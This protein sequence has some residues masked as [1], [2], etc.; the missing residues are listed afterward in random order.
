M[1]EET[2][3]KINGLGKAGDIIAK[4]CRVLLIIGFVG[5]IIGLIAIIAVP[6]DLVKVDVGTN[7]GVKVDFSR[8]GELSEA[9]QENARQ[10]LEKSLSEQDEDGR[11]AD[12]EV[13]A[14]S[15]TVHLVTNEITFGLRNLI[16]PM[17][18]ALLYVAASYVSMRFIGLLCRAFRDCASPFEEKVIR[19]MKNFA[20][21]LIPWVALSMISD[22]IISRS[23]FSVNKFSVGVN[24]GTVLLVLL[25]LGLCRIF[26]YGAE[27]Q[28][29][30]DETL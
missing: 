23:M 27:L 17:V 24:L 29:E 18:V 20:F 14:S 1:K 19:C 2:V 16:G 10:G 13:T 26:R 30:H 4:V 6:K 8:Y 21:S 22:S 3:R 15:V 7:I 5:I 9:D 28:K 11:I 12:Y 25:I